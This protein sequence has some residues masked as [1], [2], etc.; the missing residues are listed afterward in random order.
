MNFKLKNQLGQNFLINMYV[1]NNIVNVINNRYV[2]HILEIGPGF[3][4]LTKFLILKTQFLS[5]IELDANL[6]LILI[7]K[8][9]NNKNFILYNC[10]ILKLDIYI[11][12]NPL[13]KI[14]IIGNIPYYISKKLIFYF[15]QYINLTNIIYIVLQSEVIS[16]MMSVYKDKPYNKLSIIIQFNYKINFIFNIDK[17]SFRPIPSIQSGLIK[18]SPLLFINIK[19]FNHILFVLILSIA[20]NKKRK[21]IN[22][23]LKKKFINIKYLY[24]YICSKRA[25]ELQIIDYLILTNLYKN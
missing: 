4:A 20:F 24:K 9:K 22:N 19:C 8:F 1:I 25:E 18:L 13:F 12:Y 21:Y 7:R 23:S 15:I 5:A 17:S 10:N 16:N 11:L 14:K 2:Y 3:G 6:S